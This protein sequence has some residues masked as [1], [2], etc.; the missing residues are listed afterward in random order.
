MSLDRLQNARRRLELAVERLE[1]ASRGGMNGGAG[2][3]EELETVRARCAALERR[4]NDVS[5]Q[6]ETTI[7]RVKGLLED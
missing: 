5:S 3:E 6:L 2:L 4:S 1:R 7:E